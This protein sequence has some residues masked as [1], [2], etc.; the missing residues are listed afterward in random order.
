LCEYSAEERNL[1]VAAISRTIDDR[2]AVTHPRRVGSAVDSTVD[3]V[4]DGVVL[5]FASWTV[6]YHVGL[7]FGIPTNPLLVACI[8][9]GG[10]VVWF[11]SLHPNRSAA[12]VADRRRG[13]RRYLLALGT[14]AVVLA[15]GSGIILGLGGVGLWWAGWTLAVGAAVL[16]VVGVVGPYHPTAAPA[17]QRAVANGLGTVLALVTSIGLAVVSVFMR[18]ADPDDTFYVNRAQW[19]AD[20]GTIAVRDTMFTNQGLP[21]IRGSGVP[22]ASIETLQGAIAHVLHLAGGSVAFLGTPPI[23]TFLA[24]W[25]IWRLVRSWAPRRFGLCYAVAIVALL[26]S[27][28]G[29]AE[30]GVYFTRMPDG[31]V[32]FVSMLVPLVYLYLTNAVRQPDS[33]NTVMLAASGVAAVGLT[34]TAT[35]LMPLICATAAGPLLLSGRVRSA[36]RSMLPAVYPIVVGVIVHFTT[37]TANLRGGFFT[38]SSA[39]HFVFGTGGVALVGWTAVFAG[40]WLTRDAAAR[41]ITA[42][43]AAVLVIILA[44]GVLTVINDVTGAHAILWRTMWVA[45]IPVL[46]GLVAA[47]PLPSGLSWAAPVPAASLIAALLLVGL[48]LWTPR[49]NMQFTSTPAWRY[50]PDELR[51]A[52][53]IAERQLDGPVL[54][55]PLTMRALDLVTTRVHAVSPRLHYVRVLIEPAAQHR[56][57]LFLAEVIAGDLPQAPP[58]EIRVALS[59]LD[60]S[61]VCGLDRMAHRKELFS[62]AGYVAA[63]GIFGGWCLSRPG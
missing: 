5:A 39:M 9:C 51:R 24:L 1:S 38:P 18:Q 7:I 17:P 54:A 11:L 56:A 29:P 20:H 48:P 45:P 62:A 49:D 28:T 60:V 22:V 59:T 42:G 58:T 43:I 30:L 47:V 53:E 32:V 3:V 34:S 19:V 15:V 33:R 41:L 52:H 4:M 12:A 14:V 61:L 57:R 31:K 23:G 37:S 35:F 44:P 21:A 8:A 40:A 16:G 46:I 55:P 36:L 25:A 2:P 50:P 26:W 6:L 10:A 27:A 13:Q 63:P